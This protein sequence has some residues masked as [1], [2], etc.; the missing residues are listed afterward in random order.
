MY[1]A[2]LHIVRMT[3]LVL[4]L[5]AL[6][7]ASSARAVTL[8]R[9]ADIEYALKQLG[10]PVLRAAG[11]SPNQIRILVIDDSTLNA[12]I[13]D[14]QHIFIHSGLLTKLETA[15]Q[16]QAVIAHEAAHILSLIHI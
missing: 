2:A 1:H 14:T 11:L 10:A 13:V 15:A 8:L 6:I 5:T 4:C 3:G 12:F 16:V 9:D 7:G